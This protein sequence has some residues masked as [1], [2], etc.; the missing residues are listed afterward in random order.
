[1]LIE[2]IFISIMIICI[3]AVYFLCNIETEFEKEIKDI[4]RI[5]SLENKREYKYVLFNRLE[6]LADKCNSYS[7]LGKLNELLLKVY[8]L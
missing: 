8:S 5:L 7:G 1:M 4:E 6:K 2:A 3:I